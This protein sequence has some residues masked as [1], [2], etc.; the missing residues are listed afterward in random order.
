MSSTFD[1][2]VHTKSGGFHEF[3]NLPKSEVGAVQQ[4]IAS[5]GLQGKVDSGLVQEAAASQD[6]SSEVTPA[7][8][9]LPHAS[10]NQAVMGSRVPRAVHVI[11]ATA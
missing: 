8:T 3:S 4:Y 1:L 5:R 2:L 7:Q 11:L 6:G 9:G 10:S